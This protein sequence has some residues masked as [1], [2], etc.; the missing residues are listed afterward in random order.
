MQFETENDMIRAAKNGD[1]AAT[2][3]LIEKYGPAIRKSARLYSGA[4]EGD[5]AMQ[6]ATAALLGTL[7]EFDPDGEIPFRQAFAGRAQS[8]V[9]ELAADREAFSISPREHRR[10]LAL[11]RAAEGDVNVAF[12]MCN[13]GKHGMTRAKFVA[14]YRATRGTESLEDL[15]E[16][17]GDIAA[18]REV[19]AYPV[20]S[21]ER[22][23][24]TT[25]AEMDDAHYALSVLDHR[26][27]TICRHAY[28]FADE[29][30]MSDAEI[31][32]VL[33]FPTERGKAWNQ[34]SVN[35]TRAEAIVEM[36]AALTT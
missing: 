4:V 3:A 1:E 6:E 25:A 30:T 26:K 34:R 14:I 22:T 33:P 18:M 10:Y 32:T 2:V 17:N 28:G 16:G 24:M 35:R 5:D 27:R 31:A 9:G 12:A 15:T 20:T 13:G 8:A 23:V 29:H 36:R 21:D 19:A 7:A 11:L